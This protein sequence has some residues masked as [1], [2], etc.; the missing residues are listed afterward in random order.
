MFSYNDFYL[1]MLPKVYKIPLQIVA[2]N[3]INR[4]DSLKL[5]LYEVMKDSEVL[6]LNNY[7]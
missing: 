5:C 6:N 3:E 7:N 4:Q 1:S 2:E